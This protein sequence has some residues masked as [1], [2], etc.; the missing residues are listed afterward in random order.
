MQN[1]KREPTDQSVPQTH[2]GSYILR[3]GDLPVQDFQKEKIFPNRK[4]DLYQKSIKSEAVRKKKRKNHYKISTHPCDS[5]F[6]K[7]PEKIV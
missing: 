4:I 7:K 2:F 5:R 1:M 6:L 3:K